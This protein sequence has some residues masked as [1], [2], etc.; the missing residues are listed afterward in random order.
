MSSPVH[1]PFPVPSIFLILLAVGLIYGQTAGFEF[2]NWD[3]N[4]F[5]YLE[6]GLQQGWTADS[7]RWIFAMPERAFF[8][9][10]SRLSYL[11]DITLFDLTPGP[12]H[13][14][15]TL[16]HGAN[17]VLV[18]FLMLR[19]RLPHEHSLLAAFLFAVH[20]Q[21][22]EAVVWIAERKELLSMFFGML[23]LL[24]YLTALRLHGRLHGDYFLAS[25]FCLLLSLLAKPLW[26]TLPFILLLLDQWPLQRPWSWRLVGEK[27]PYWLVILLFASLTIVVYLLQDNLTSL[28]EVSLA[29]RFNNAL[30]A[31]GLFIW[32][33]LFPLALAPYYP[34][35]SA[36]HGD[37]LILLS[38]FFLLA[39]SLLAWGWRSSRPAL[40][41]GWLWFLGSLVPVSGLVNAGQ[42]VAM[43]DRWSYFSHLGLLLI[44]FAAL[45]PSL[46]SSTVKAGFVGVL[47]VFAALAWQQ[48]TYWQNSE[49][50][51][52]ATLKVVPQEDA[53]PIHLL[54][55]LHYQDQGKVPE[56][57]EQVRESNRL[58]PKDFST[59]LV[60]ANLYEQQG[61]QPLAEDLYM[62]LL[63]LPTEIPQPLLTIGMNW[64]KRGETAKA[65]KFFQKL[66]TLQRPSWYTYQQDGRLF[67]GLTWWM[68]GDEKQA[69]VQWRDYLTNGGT[70][71]PKHCQIAEK[72]LQKEEFRQLA[73]AK[74]GLKQL[75]K[76]P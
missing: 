75:C 51:W 58:N 28:Q 9:P 52:K 48:T 13:V 55:G 67:L 66:A 36:G 3:D 16:L 6:P 35:P 18:F 30:V 20:P 42:V 12:M 56:A 71:I 27:W 64:L 39:V 5:V 37:A 44:L 32:K 61:Q 38:A 8:S 26:V 68:E 74:E 24:A 34:V 7:W 46:L 65:R 72:V 22:V 2:V 25:V 43:T 29:N 4:L 54:L 69:L 21:H 17:S 63:S 60:L 41:V 47:L 1:R 73:A 19:L 49:T 53:A 76:A 15:N 10:L 31:Y 40:A 23:S 50:L 33:S 59:I 57:L 70:P 14:V 62:Q 45:L 11:I